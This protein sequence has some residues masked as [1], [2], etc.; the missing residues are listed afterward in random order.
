MLGW[1]LLTWRNKRKKISE[2]FGIESRGLLIPKSV[3]SYQIV[4]N[5]HEVQNQHFYAKKKDKAWC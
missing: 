2:P 4:L 1:N 5:T 3:P